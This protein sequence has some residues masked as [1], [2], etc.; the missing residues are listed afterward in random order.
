MGEYYIKRNFKKEWKSYIRMLI[1]YKLCK[2][3]AIH[4]KTY[5]DLRKFK[6]SPSSFHLCKG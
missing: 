6:T 1:M 4:I 2:V 3:K 5:H